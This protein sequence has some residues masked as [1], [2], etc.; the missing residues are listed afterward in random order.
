MSDVQV[1]MIVR[2]FNMN[3][4][5]LESKIHEFFSEVNVDTQITDSSGKQH[6]PREWFSAPLHVIEEAIRLIN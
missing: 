3:V 4:K 5:S 2:C 6:F 1:I